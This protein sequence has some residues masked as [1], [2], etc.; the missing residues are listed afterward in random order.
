M[1]IAEA[2]SARIQQL[3]LSFD[4]VARRANMSVSALRNLRQAKH[5]PHTSTL[6]DLSRALG[7][8]TVHLEAVRDKAT[9]PAPGSAAHQAAAEVGGAEQ[10]IERILAELKVDMN[11]GFDR[12]IA[13]VDRR[14]AA[15][16]RKVVGRPQ[17]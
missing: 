10:A 2:V 15:L 8:H 3:H 17:R 12:V 14:F 1:R 11:N 4:E 6:R 16:E 7:W 5:H 9:P 13:H